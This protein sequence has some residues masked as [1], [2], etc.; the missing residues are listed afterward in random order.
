MKLAGRMSR[1][2]TESAFDVLAQAQA[3]EAAGV[4]VIHLEIGD[5]DSPTPRHICEA[6][7]HA[8]RSGETHY[9][10]SQ[11]TVPLREEIAREIEHTRGISV[12]P[13]RI[14]VGPGAKP[15]AF[16]CMLALLDHGDEVLYPSPLFPVFEST[17]NFTG[18]KP[19]PV[20]LHEELDFR[21]DIAELASHVRPQ[22]KLLVLNSPHN[23]T[24]GVLEKE[25]IQQI[26]DL[27]RSRDIMV[28]SDEIY[29]H[30]VY[31]GQ[32]PSI[33]SVPDML[34]RTILIGG[35]S[36]TYAMTGWRLGYAVLPPELVEPIVRLIINSVS[37][38]PPFI[39]SAALHALSGPQ[40]DCTLM[41]EDLRR[42]RDFVVSELNRI[43]GIGCRCPR[44]AFYA[45]PN[46][47]GVGLSCEELADHLLKQAGVATLPGTAFGEYGD[48]HL[49]LSYTTSM[50]NLQEAMRRMTSTIS[51][52][53]L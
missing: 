9:C 14:V 18:A 47:R 48:G 2:G 21:L 35:F 24:G 41:V 1:L 4:Q 17:I 28:L 33:A 15:L 13:S 26:A 31:D 25:D 34:D 37:C 3:L 5:T 30:I 36:K 49:R 46:V 29:D 40:E 8:M 22:T 52:L 53:S 19:V 39:Q 11:G 16:Y 7:A 38:A 51:A 27:T 23:P 20:P 50:A 44:G 32:A 10:N 45:F 43:P 12:D 42:R 6:A